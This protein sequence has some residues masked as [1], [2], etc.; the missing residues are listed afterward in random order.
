MPKIILHPRARLC[1]AATFVALLGLSGCGKA[2]QDV[3]GSIGSLGASST[4]PSD[5]AAL[6][7]FADDWGRRYD[8]TPK[9]KTTA[10]T[11][12][13]ALHALDR[14]NEAVSVLQSLSIQNPQDMKVLAAYGKALADSGRL[15][16]AADILSKSHTP[17]RPDWSVLSTQ[18]TIA[19]Q[20]GNHEEARAY[21]EEALKI[22]PEEPTVLS[23]LGLSYALSKQ[24]PRA[25]ETLLRAAN[26]PNADMRVR[27]N[28]ALVLALEGKFGE[29]EEWSR[30]DL[31]PAEATTNVATIRQ[32]ISQSN[33][34][35]DISGPAEDKLGSP[36]RPR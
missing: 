7:R 30:R 12:A 20:M 33:T 10:L 1:A 14:N 17:E 2:V 31:S 36:R 5:P 25:E 35:R 27:Q 6:R 3:T 22:R 28:L 32:M 19:D 24:L 26:T 29:A 4:P 8:A 9:D 11:Y 21:Y 34:W 23:N 16:E 15:Q 18:G 13:R